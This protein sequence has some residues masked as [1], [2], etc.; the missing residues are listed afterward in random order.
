MMRTTVPGEEW[1]LSLWPKIKMSNF[2]DMSDDEDY[3]T[4]WRMTMKNDDEVWNPK[5]K[6]TNILDTRYVWWWGLPGEEWRRSM[7]PKN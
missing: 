3:G 7:G 6:I 1:R 4:G 2:I 5:I